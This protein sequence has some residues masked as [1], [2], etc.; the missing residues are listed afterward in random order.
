M[1]QCWPRAPL[2]FYRRLSQ[3]SLLHD[4]LV[5]EDWLVCS[6]GTNRNA[7][8]GEAGS[9]EREAGTG[10]AGTKILLPHYHRGRPLVFEGPDLQHLW[11]R[12]APGLPFVTPWL[13][14]S[15]SQRV[16]FSVPV[17]PRTP[18]RQTT[19]PVLLCKWQHSAPGLKGGQGGVR[20]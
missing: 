1:P 8:R 17:S 7:C 12:W 19:K 11:A 20:V 15:S 3:W 10:P 4:V 9:R 18:P 13:V 6:R 5:I 16:S 2:A 14:L